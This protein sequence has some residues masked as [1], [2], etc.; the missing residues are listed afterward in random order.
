MRKILMTT[1]LALSIS[2]LYAQEPLDAIRYSWMTSQ[3]TARAQS[4]GGAT[5]A[6]GGDIT[7]LYSNP[8]GLGLYK[9]GEI[10]L[11]P[12]FNFISNKSSYRGG[13]ASDNKSGFT[14]GPIGLVYGIPSRTGSKWKNT[15]LGVGISRSADFNNRIY[16]DG[17]NNQSSF[18]EKYLD[19]LFNGNATNPDNAAVDYPYGASLGL[20]TYLIDPTYDDD[21]NLTGYAS[22]ASVPTGVRQQQVIS[23]K[24]GISDFSIGVGA[25]YNDV[26]YI[27]G[28]LNIN[29]LR[30]TRTS[31]FT[32]SDA[33]NDTD[34][35]FNYF[36][37]EDY[38]KTD[39]VGASI[40]LGIMFKPVEALRVGISFHSPSWYSFK[41]TYTSSL[42]TD[43]EGYEG[44]KYQS[45]LDLNDGYAGEYNYRY[46]TPMRL[47][48]GLAYMFGTTGDVKTQR[49]FITADIEYVSYKGNA[50][51]SQDNSNTDD[52]DYFSQLN[53]TIDDVFKNTINMRV[54]GELKFETIM[55]RAGFGYYGNPYTTKYF[56][57]KQQDMVDGSRMN[58]TGGLGWRNKGVFVDL[59]YIHQIVNDGYYPYRL[60][61][62][63]FSPVSLKSTSGTVLLTVGFKF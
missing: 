34:N 35:D 41:D 49:G 23:T 36:K 15:T 25:N 19:Q 26:F 29:T 51:N 37:A 53:G 12:G 33:T 31:T 10:V 2:I 1:G 38:L 20:N 61:V 57:N 17:N 47:G 52:K 43:T 8:A 46:R 48:A 22:N 56:D 39:G 55:V 6:L 63:E 27:G 28:S 24:G 13:S 9:T 59:A 7:S 14:Y 5:T 42:E 50:F 30:F 60:D 21:G 40:K 4:I 54:G 62:S 58:I 11:T 18:S 32:E 45:S 3:G 16:V 44:V